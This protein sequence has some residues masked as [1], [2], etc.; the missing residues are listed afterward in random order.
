MEALWKNDDS[1][2]YISTDI[3]SELKLIQKI[4]YRFISKFTTDEHLRF[5]F[6]HH[7]MLLQNR[8]LASDELLRIFP[9]NLNS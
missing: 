7:G 4:H 6:T 8:R 5:V 9:H 3:A 1:D 2:D